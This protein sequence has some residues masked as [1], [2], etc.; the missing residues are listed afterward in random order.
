MSKRGN[1]RIKT[2]LRVEINIAIVGDDIAGDEAE[3]SDEQENDQ[4]NANHL[5]ELLVLL[6]EKLII[7]IFLFAKKVRVIETHVVL[8]ELSGCCGS[9]STEGVLIGLSS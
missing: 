4:L 1:I 2:N 7:G 6:L 9:Y 3:Y 5:K 8:L